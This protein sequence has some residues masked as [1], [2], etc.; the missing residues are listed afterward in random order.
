MAAAR[1][2]LRPVRRAVAFVCVGVGGAVWREA[3]EHEHT[4]LACVLV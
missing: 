2:D 4:L 3:T 1:L